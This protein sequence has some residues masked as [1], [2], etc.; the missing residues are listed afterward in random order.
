MSKFRPNL[1]ISK[2]ATGEVWEGI[3]AL[4]VGL[5]DEIKTSDVYILEFI[6]K[7]DVYS[8]KFEPKKNLQDKFSKFFK[9]LLFDSLG[10][11]E[12][13]FDKRKYK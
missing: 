1:D 4:E 9:A 13:F 10:S 6:N 3:E 5:V 12:D 11:V 7:H 8:I 2:I